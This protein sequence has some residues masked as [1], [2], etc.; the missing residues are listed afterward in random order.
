VADREGLTLQ[1]V[2]GDILPRDRLAPW[3]RRPV[4]L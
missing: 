2:H 1:H 4:R 3:A